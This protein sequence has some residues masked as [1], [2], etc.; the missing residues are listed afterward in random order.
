[1]FSGV[2]AHGH[3]ALIHV[4]QRMSLQESTRWGSAFPDNLACSYNGDRHLGCRLSGNERNWIPFRSSMVKATASLIWSACWGPDRC[5]LYLP[6]GSG[7]AWNGTA[8]SQM[9]PTCGGGL[10][11]FMARA[12]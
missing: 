7:F 4:G 1:M 3:R 5:A 12:I 10:M 6:R 11:R 8:S 2:P 9:I